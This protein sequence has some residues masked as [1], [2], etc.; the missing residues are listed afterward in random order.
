MN[1][2]RRRLLTIPYNYVNPAMRQRAQGLVAMIWAA[3][4]VILLVIAVRALIVLL[5][6]DRTLVIAPLELVVGALVLLVSYWLIQ[7]GRLD[8]AIWLFLGAMLVPFALAT[9][10]AV[11]PAAP[12]I[13]ILPLV[14]AGVLLNRRSLVP[15]LVI[16][17]VT[18]I[19]RAVNQGGTSDAIR[20]V[21]QD[22]ALPELLNY[23]IVFGLSAIFL[24]VFS[25][26]IEQIVAVSFSDLEQL[27]AVGKFSGRLDDS[28]DEMIIFTRLLEIVERDLGFDL[29][30]IYLRDAEGKYTRRLRLGLTQIEMGTR[31]VLRG[32]DEAVINEAI[33]RREPIIVTTRDD[34]SRSEHLVPPSR[35]SVTLALVYGEQV[36]GVLDIQSEHREMF[37]ENV[38]GGL[39]NLVAEVARE[40]VHARRFE[41]LLRSVHD[42]EAI[43]DR[44]L[45][46]MSELQRRSETAAS[47]GWARYL[48]GR[49]Q[50]GF[51]FDF[52]DGGIAPASDLPD[53]IRQTVERGEI[54]IEQG[55]AEQT[56]SVPIILRDQRLGALT[57]TVPA[58]R[59][60]D[61]RQIEML[62][63]VVNRLSVALENNRL[64]EQ[65]QA[66]AQRERKASEIGSLMLSE[67]DI[68][69]VLEVAAENFNEALG[70]VHTRVYLEPG[71]LSGEAQS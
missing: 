54:A 62:R 38:I 36:F 26:S 42:Q 16:F 11:D 46:Q 61:E 10:I 56:V 29:A 55:D 71:I 3:I 59:G 44:F 28:T 53:S 20:Y 22:N 68:E 63:T 39:R 64:F 48:E 17:A 40:L 33:L 66:Q 58:E 5:N 41:E 57:F 47:V 45:S 67:T 51:G 60:V 13:L 18:M 23:G 9:A 6:L 70:A 49:G 24:L 7:R 37:T 25:G 12:A 32:G 14:A 35:Q 8:A 2:L 50:E 19:L 34:L 4:L 21:P 52:A 43:I 1:A 15:I 27:R 30:Q 31:I 69:A 65:T